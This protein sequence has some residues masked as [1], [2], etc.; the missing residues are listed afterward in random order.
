[1]IPIVIGARETVAKGFEAGGAWRVV[2]R[3]TNRDHQDHSMTEIG[4]NIPKSPQDMMR[5]AVTQTPMKDHQV[6]LV[7]KTLKE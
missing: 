5:L 2:N 1:M 7:R 4:Q 3:W 6:S